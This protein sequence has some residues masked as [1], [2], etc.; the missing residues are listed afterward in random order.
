[1]EEELA[2]EEDDDHE[3]EG[4]VKALGP[5]ATLTGLAWARPAA[6]A[7]TAIFIMADMLFE[8][9][10]DCELV[11]LYECCWVLSFLAER[12]CD[13]WKEIQMKKRKKEIRKS[14]LGVL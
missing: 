10:D 5:E 8:V 4:L 6:R 3:F 1:M 13:N 7:A 12:V 11:G 14:G 2:T 9:L